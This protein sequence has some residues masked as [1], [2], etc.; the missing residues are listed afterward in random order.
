MKNDTAEKNLSAETEHRLE[1]MILSGQLK[2][3]E[4]LPT[5]RELAEAMG[6][7]KGVIHTG[8][9]SLSRKGFVR[10]A[11]RHGV[12]V[13]DYIKNGTLD[14]LNTIASYSDGNIDG[15]LARSIA[16]TR[17]ALE[18]LPVYGLAVSHTPEQIN[19]LNMMLRDMRMAIRSG[20]VKTSR[21]LAGRIQEF[22]LARCVMSGNMVLPVIV[23]A[24]SEVSVL[25]TE[26]WIDKV[27]FDAALT[28]LE[29]TMLRVTMGD[30]GGAVASLKHNISSA[31]DALDV[32]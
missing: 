5:E 22:F 28:G 15:D 21:E 2:I 26:K 1:A 19:K 20:K 17:F 27:G 18:Y 30:G 11:P 25:L 32:K 6:V 4:Q 7:S 16:W 14:V 13:A 24:S 10:V 12:Y 29:R 31:I 3:G 8:I 23:N 9:A